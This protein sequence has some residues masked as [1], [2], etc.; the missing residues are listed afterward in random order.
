MHHEMIAALR[1]FIRI[2]EEL[3]HAWVDIGGMVDQVF[4]VSND[5][6]KV[7]ITLVVA[8]HE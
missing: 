7:R 5:S 1:G 4:H 6:E 3:A 2:F 8:P